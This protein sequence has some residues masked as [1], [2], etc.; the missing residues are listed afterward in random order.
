MTKRMLIDATHPEETRVVILDGDRIDEFDFETSTK[1]R[2]KGNIYLAKITRVEP[3][4]QAAFVEYGGDRHGFLAFNEIHPDYYQLPIADRRALAEQE[5]TSAAADEPAGTEDGAEGHDGEAAEAGGDGQDV[6]VVG[7][8]EVDHVDRRR[9][10]PSR[11]YRM[12]EVIKRRQIMLVQVVKEERGTK[13]AALTTYISL[14]GRYCVVMPNAPRGGGISRRIVD[15]EDRKRLRAIAAELDAPEGMGVILRTAGM[16]RSK[17]EIKRDF[18]YLVALWDDS[19]ELTLRST[20]PTIIHEEANL[21]KRSIRDLYSREIEEVLVEGDEGYR[22]AKAFMRT[23]VPSHAKRVKPYNDRIPLF[24]HFKVEGQ[25]DAMHSP[26]AYLKSG[27]S[28]VISPTEALVAIDVNSG[29][30]TRERHIDETSLKTNLEAADEIARQLRLRDL[31]GLI[32]IDFIDMDDAKSVRAVERR[33]KEAMKIDRAR[34][35]IGHISSFGLLE[36]SR[37]RLRP[38]LLEASSQVCPHCNGSGHIRSIEST[39]L[40][41]LRAIEAE[42]IEAR[43]DEITV[44][45]PTNVALYI[46][47]QKRD[48]LSAIEKGCGLRVFIASD[49]SLIAPDYRLERAK[50]GAPVKVKEA[51][52]SKPAEDEGDGAARK[53]GRRRP[54]RRG[55]EEAEAPAAEAAEDAAGERPTAAAVDAGEAEDAAEAPRKRRRRGKRGGRRR[56][57]A[58][59]VEATSAEAAAAEAS[60]A[61]VAAEAEEPAAATADT[62]AADAPAESRPESGADDAA[63]KPKRSRR[64]GRGKGVAE[65]PKGARPRRVRSATAESAAVEAE[66]P[67]E[68]APAAVDAHAVPESPV[69]PRETAEQWPRVTPSTP[70]A[71]PAPVAAEPAPER[72]QEPREAAEE[73]PRVTPSEPTPEPEPT[74]PPAGQPKPPPRRGW[75]RRPGA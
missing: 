12:Q 62:P 15:A 71:E 53:R 41:V 18:N 65:K 39:V 35:Q 9:L 59:P 70:A 47:N 50:A 6:E 51:S 69:E 43:S 58:T 4:L 28:V 1:K 2:L 67:A 75:W 68:P 42:G 54:K 13:G 21:I 57:A 7:G 30:A 36:L 34:I 44:F 24:Q 46:F 74:V 63:A 5:A 14:A 33:L 40:H 3:S 8:N 66:S 60:G 22:M 29:K 56:R 55:G 72:P 25:L 49:D 73:P 31:A 45:V 32:V 37:Q 38:S 23:L 26:I 52:K 17:A 16:K 20:A 61:P 10:H 64:S 11:R 27:G 48:V 19:R